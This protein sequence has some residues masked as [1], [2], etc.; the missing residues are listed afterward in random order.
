M[1]NLSSVLDR[2]VSDPVEVSL[3]GEH[4]CAPE[5]DSDHTLL[6]LYASVFP[7]CPGRLNPELIILD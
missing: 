7:F 6:S 1:G 4:V 3:R 2:G 5:L